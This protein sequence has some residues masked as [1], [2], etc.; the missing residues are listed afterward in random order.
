MQFFTFNDKDSCHMGYDGAVCVAGTVSRHLFETSG[1]NDATTKRCIPEGSH[2]YRIIARIASNY[3]EL[4]IYITE[5][6][7][8][9]MKLNHFLE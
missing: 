3:Y 8:L 6:Y 4:L 1:I 2:P 7:I 5:I 9:T